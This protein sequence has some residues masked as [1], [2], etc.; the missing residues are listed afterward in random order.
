MKMT[1]H[2]VQRMNQRGINKNML[3]M[4]MEFGTPH[5]GRYS[6]NKK[7]ANQVIVRLQR[8]LNDLK[9]IAD[10][11]GITVVMENDTYITAWNKF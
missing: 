4:V 2:A 7:E 10:K 11:G 3:D 6:L 8:M 5:N 1:R 9:R